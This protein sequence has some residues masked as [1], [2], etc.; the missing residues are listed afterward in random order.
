MTGDW[1]EGYQKPV[2]AQNLWLFHPEDFSRNFCIYLR[3][4]LLFQWDYQPSLKWFQ[5][6]LLDHL[7]SYHSLYVGFS[8]WVLQTLNYLLKGDYCFRTCFIDRQNFFTFNIHFHHRIK[9]LT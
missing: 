7:L 6:D 3:C 9:I 5:Y 1:L 4:K 8:D 2:F